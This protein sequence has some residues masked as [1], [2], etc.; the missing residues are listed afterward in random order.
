MATAKL[1]YDDMKNQIQ[2]VF[3]NTAGNADDKTEEYNCTS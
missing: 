2:K 1:N 3:G